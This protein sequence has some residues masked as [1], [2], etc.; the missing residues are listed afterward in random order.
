MH[1]EAAR[2]QLPRERQDDRQVGSSLSG[3]GVAD[4]RDHSSRPR[5]SPRQTAAAMVAQV[6]QLRRLRWNGWRIAL[7]LSQSRATISRILCPLGLDRL[8]PLNSPPP[9]GA[10]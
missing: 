7:K 4:L 1:V 9:G 5:H 2:G 10:L 3:H 6:E 8:R